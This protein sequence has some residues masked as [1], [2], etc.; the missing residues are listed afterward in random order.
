MKTALATICT[1]YHKNLWER[2]AADSWRRYAAAQGYEIVLFERPLDP[3]PE[4]AERKVS[5]QKMLLLE[6]PELQGFDR[7]VW[8]DA[9]IYINYLTAPPIHRNLP[10]DKIGICEEMPYPANPIFQRGVRR[11][12]QRILQSMKKR[13]GPEATDDLYELCGFSGFKGPLFNNGVFVMT[14][15]EQR[16]FLRACYD[17]YF[18]RGRDGAS[19]E[20]V[21][22]SYE[23]A[24]QMRFHRLDPRFN[25]LYAKLQYSLLVAPTEDPLV[26]GRIGL[27]AGAIANSYFLHFA[28]RHNDMRFCRYV[29]PDRQQGARIRPIVVKRH[30]QRLTSPATDAPVRRAVTDGAAVAKSPAK[31]AKGANQKKAEHR[32]P[33]SSAD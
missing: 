16:E 6:Q 13:F 31:K 28:G 5:W 1:G 20:M 21:P 9:D 15:S 19:F 7:V 33:R 32:A 12:R 27:T 29:V 26:S 11:A 30:L 3:R 24:T 2:C 22:F 25:V 10:A 23:L 14:A 18:D 17:R 4:A 8:I